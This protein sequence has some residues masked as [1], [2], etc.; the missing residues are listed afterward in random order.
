MGALTLDYLMRDMP[1]ATPEKLGAAAGRKIDYGYEDIQALRSELIEALCT[2]KKLRRRGQLNHPYKADRID[3]F[4]SLFWP[5][6]RA[7]ARATYRSL[8]A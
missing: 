6:L 1:V 7:P 8:A 4:R 3:F 2:N 5:A